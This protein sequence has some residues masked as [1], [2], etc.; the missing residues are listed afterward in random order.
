MSAYSNRVQAEVLASHQ[1][2]HQVPPAIRLR[3]CQL[4]RLNDPLG[5]QVSQ[6]DYEQAKRELVRERILIL[7]EPSRA[8]FEP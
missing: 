6:D 2:L 5:G 7:E 8:L 3:S 4:V 1:E